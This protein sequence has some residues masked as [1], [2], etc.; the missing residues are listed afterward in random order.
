MKKKFDFRIIIIVILAVVLIGIIIAY[1]NS[2]DSDTITDEEKTLYA[3]WANKESQTTS[4][5]SKISGSGEITSAL[6]EKLELHSTYYY[7]EIYVE[8]NRQILQGEN[9]LKYTNGE[10]LVAPYDCVITEISVPEVNGKCTNQHY[11]EVSAIHPLE[12]SISVSETKIDKLAVGQEVTIKVKA[13]G[14][15]FSGY[16]TNISSTANNGNFIVKVEFENN[17]NVKLGMTANVEIEV[18]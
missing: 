17:G 16:I 10:Y 4:N 8:E 3:N 18:E 5:V 11:I 12:V 9:I 13:L 2:V 6:I 1:S 7:S 14:E 15:T